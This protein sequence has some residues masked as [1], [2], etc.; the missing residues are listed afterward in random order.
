MKKAPQTTEQRLH[1]ILEKHSR[2]LRSD[3]LEQL[4]TAEG[5]LRE[6]LVFSEFGNNDVMK[7]I[8]KLFAK[9]IT[10]MNEVILYKHALT[11]EERNRMF[12]KRQMYLNFLNF[13]SKAE[14]TIDE[15]G[16]MVED[17][18]ELFTEDE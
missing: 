4:T 13:F 6:A 5:K 16:K 18:K 11:T 10:E 15:I 2:E 14:V 7:K 1:K 8:R 17:S 12:D 9:Y 3:F